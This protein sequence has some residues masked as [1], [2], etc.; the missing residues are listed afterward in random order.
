M[1]WQKGLLFVRT[2]LN[3]LQSVPIYPFHVWKTCLTR[4]VSH[5]TLSSQ[6]WSGM[7]SIDKIHIILQLS[8]KPLQQASLSSKMESC[9]YRP[10]YN[11]RVPSFP[12]LCYYRGSHL[13]KYE[14][15][16]HQ[17]K[18][19][20]SISFYTELYWNDIL[21]PQKPFQFDVRTTNIYYYFVCPCILFFLSILT[22]CCTLVL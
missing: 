17:A 16:H 15:Y 14:N 2:T 19:R 12:T 8:R 3:P 22:A 7:D 6:G 1:L 18:S 11:A 13:I 21:R 10:I 5:F 4:T 20:V 9:G